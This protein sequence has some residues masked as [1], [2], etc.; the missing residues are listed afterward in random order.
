MQLGRREA[1][2]A[3]VEPI[4]VVLGPFCGGTSAVA[5]V[6]HHLGVFMGTAFYLHHPPYEPPDTWED[7]GLAELCRRAFSE[8]GGQFHM[9]AASFEAELRRWA[10]DHRRT[11]RIARRRPGAK[12]PSL[13]LAV[14]FIQ[15][16]WDPVL[17]VVVDRPT[18]DVVASLNRRKWWWNEQNRI[19][20][21]ARLIEARDRALDHAATIRV[22]FEALR[23]MP[24]LVIRRLADELCLEV[25]QAQVQ[26]AAQSIAR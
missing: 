10:N 21:T 26:A 19:T 5:G 23:A 17:P 25:T 14:D 2:L 15:D 11:A 1:V 16:A 12:H 13:C 24:A 18:A 6:L 9:D 22:E 8:P 20:T 4:I 3:P 7:L